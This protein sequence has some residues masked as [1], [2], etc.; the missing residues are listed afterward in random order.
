MV[1]QTRFVFL[2]LPI[3]FTTGFAS[4][5]DVAEENN[6]GSKKVSAKI[7]KLFDMMLPSI[8]NFILKHGLDPMQL[9]D[10]SEKLV[11]DLKTRVLNL[12]NGW[13]Q[14]LSEVRRAN[15]IILSYQD[16]VVTVDVTL[17]FDVAEASYKYLLKDLLISRKGD[18][19]GGIRNM[20]L[21][22]IIEFD[23][24]SYKLALPMVKIVNVEKFN[25]S[26]EGNIDD[27]LLNAVAKAITDVFRANIINIVN[28]EFSKEV[29]VLVDE[30]N[31]KIP[32]PNQLFDYS[33]VWDYV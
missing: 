12:T 26:F 3:L 16:K 10:L 31:K 28:Q 20:Q 6:V 1:L 8:H 33:N 2:L 13:L 25:V 14:G 22:I 32:R 27:P 11:V 24:N 23:M 29:K 4:P 18:V 7:N 15:D 21:R 19:H 9:P 30:I 17:M 5:L